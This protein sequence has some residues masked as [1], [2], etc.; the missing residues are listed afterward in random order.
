[1]K[2]TEDQISQALSPL[3]AGFEAD[4]FNLK[5]REIGESAIVFEL[6][7]SPDAC[8]ECILPPSSMEHLLVECLRSAGIDNVT[9]QVV[10]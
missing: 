10:E 6:S 2:P 9:V 7:K 1:M 8:E 5:L 3:A 4:G